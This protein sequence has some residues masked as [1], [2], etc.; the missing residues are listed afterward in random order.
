MGW[1]EIKDYSSTYEINVRKVWGDNKTVNE[2]ELTECIK[3]K[4]YRIEIKSDIVTSWV[5]EVNR[6]FA[7][8]N[9]KFK[10]KG[11]SIIISTHPHLIAVDATEIAEIHVD[12]NWI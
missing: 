7:I 1:L 8:D 2:G 3:Q 6:Y 11:K 12:V 10:S 9:K 4:V 5:K